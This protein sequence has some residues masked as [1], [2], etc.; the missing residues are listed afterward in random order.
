METQR[1]GVGWAARVY[2]RVHA[3]P[4]HPGGPAGADAG[5]ARAG[6]GGLPVRRATLA[7]AEHEGQRSRR[8]RP[9]VPRS[10]DNR[11]RTAFTTRST[12]RTP[13][14][15]TSCSQTRTTIQPSFRSW[16][17]TR[18]SRRRLPSIFCLQYGAI[19]SFQVGKRQPC[20]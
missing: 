3:G 4:A 17:V 7:P 5:E 11:R 19:L 15:S 12:Q 10:R 1:R 13:F 14:R 18:L 6:A 16:R 2:G 20:Q 9:V 8:G